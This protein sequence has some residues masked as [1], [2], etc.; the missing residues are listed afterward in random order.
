MDENC[1]NYDYH[2]FQHPDCDDFLN[3]LRE[4]LAE[5]ADSDANFIPLGTS[6]LHKSL[7]KVRQA[8]RSYTFVAKQGKG[9]AHLWSEKLVYDEMEQY[10]GRHVPICLGLLELE[11]PRQGYRQQFNELLLLSWAGRPFQNCL[12][13]TSRDRV[14][15]KVEDIL[16]ALHNQD[17]LYNGCLEPSHFLYDASRDEVMI[18]DFGESSTRFTH[19][20]GEDRGGYL[21]PKKRK[22]GLPD[23]AMLVFEKDMVDAVSTILQSAAPSHERRFSELES[24]IGDDSLSNRW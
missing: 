18:V 15:S 8:A 12:R 11:R 1:P 10:Q 9:L 14:A 7:F 5:G 2:G 24:E 4:Q 16:Q 20:P 21:M 23:S 13:Q 19:L 17:I 6:S 22:R 3:D